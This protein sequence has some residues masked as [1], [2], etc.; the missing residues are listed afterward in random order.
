MKKILSFVFILCL[1][2]M[3]Y[4]T[5]VLAADDEWSGKM[6]PTSATVKVGGTVTVTAT[7]TGKLRVNTMPTY[8]SSDTSVATVDSKGVVTGKKVGKATI[9]GKF[10]NLV[11]GT[12]TVTVG[13][14]LDDLD[15]PT[16]GNWYATLEPASATLKVGETVT[17][18]SEQH[19]S[20]IVKTFAT[21][22]SNNTSVA[23]VDHMS[24]LVTAKSAGNA[25]ITV[26]YGNLLAGTVPITVTN[27]ANPQTGTALYIVAIVSGIIALGTS[28]WYFRKLISVS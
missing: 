8:T 24:G 18:K 2:F 12:C 27:N 13:A 21:F 16:D 14:S 28:I 25:V 19:G 11:A 5:T 26:K 6:T 3:L 7:Q 20:N 1:T 17:I 10:G 15:I 22:E 9:T 4:Q 23:T